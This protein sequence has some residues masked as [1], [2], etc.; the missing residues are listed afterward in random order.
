M[1]GLRV[2][3]PGAGGR[4]SVGPNHGALHLVISLVAALIAVGDRENGCPWI[5]ELL[6]R[7]FVRI[8]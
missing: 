8:L 2:V 1:L 5:Y 3:F 4:P 6:D 7:I